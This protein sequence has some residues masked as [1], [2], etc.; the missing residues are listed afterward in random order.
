MPCRRKPYTQIGIRRVPCF[1]CGRPAE[2]QWQICAD[3]NLWRPLCTHCDVAINDC[4]L[5][6][7]RDPNRKTK[8]RRYREQVAA[9]LRRSA[10]RQKL[11]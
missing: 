5:R 11:K 4:V 1:R 10:G 7:M 6:F 9:D 2:H 3:G 8:M